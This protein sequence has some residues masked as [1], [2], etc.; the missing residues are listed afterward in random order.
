MSLSQPKNEGDMTTADI[1]LN[2]SLQSLIGARI[3]WVRDQ[4]T[5][6][7][8]D[9]AELYGVQT[10][11]LVQPVKRNLTRF[12]QDF[13]FQLT[14]DE[15][16]VLRSQIVTSNTGRGGRR[17]APKEALIKSSSP[18]R[19]GSSAL[20]FMNSRPTRREA[21][22]RVCQGRRNDNLTSTSQPSHPTTPT[23]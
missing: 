11:V 12:P 2:A 9:L 5:M 4:R 1:P 20:I 10:K 21:E 7:D 13:M 16:A 8:S 17:T 6:L 3:L 23:P 15:F 22:S 18:R 19:R 14:A